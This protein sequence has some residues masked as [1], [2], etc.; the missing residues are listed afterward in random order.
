MDSDS[1]S[2]SSV[3]AA[4]G[5]WHRRGAFAVMASDLRHIRWLVATSARVGAIY[6]LAQIPAFFVPI[7]VAATFGVTTATDVFFLAFAVASFVANSVNG[8]A[9][10]A[11]PFL[12]AEG[13][14][15]LAKGACVLT[16]IAAGLLLV[17]LLAVGPA[18]ERLSELGPAQRRDV[19]L[20]LVALAPFVVLSAVSAMWASATNATRD[21]SIAAWA[22]VLRSLVVLGLVLALG[23][24]AGLWGLVLAF[25]A[26]EVARALVLWARVSRT[27]LA[28][29]PPRPGGA[30]RVGGRALARSLVAQV[31]GSAIIGAVPII[32]RAWA[33]SLGPGS[34]SVLEYAERIWQVPL[35]LAMTGFTVVSLTEW[36]RDIQAGDQALPVRW[37][38]AATARVL[39]VSSLP[40]CLTFVIFREPIVGMLFGYGAF[41]TPELPR[42]ADTLAA[43]VAGVPVYLI[44]LAYSRVFLVSMRS[45]ILLLAALAGVTCKIGLN[46]WLVGHWG[47]AGLGAATSIMFGLNTLLL[48][49][50]SQTP[51]FWA[52]VNR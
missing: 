11:V 16:A 13:R 37:Q 29:V 4:G 14:R 3:R 42:L 33:S 38:V 15:L 12:V 35:S 1:V 24:S 43:L 30:H 52:A 28:T 6:L 40:F 19:A 39:F 18:L 9:Q 51:G 44:G 50:A 17:A 5:A 36:S 21:Y 32:D 20:F 23:P 10:A 48:V 26:S 27:T 46:G 2:A 34:V 41:P 7:A 47:V 8:P 49:A 22:Q 31:A 25:V 45:D